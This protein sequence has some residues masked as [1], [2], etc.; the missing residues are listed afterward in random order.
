MDRCRGTNSLFVGGF[1]NSCRLTDANLKNLR[2]INQD[3]YTLNSIFFFR[4]KILTQE[5][6]RSEL[7]DR[8]LIGTWTALQYHP[9]WNIYSPPHASAFFMKS[10]KIYNPWGL[11]FLKSGNIRSIWR[12]ITRSRWDLFNRIL[13]DGTEKKGVN[14]WMG[15]LWALIARINT[16]FNGMGS[17]VRGM[18]DNIIS[19]LFLVLWK[20]WLVYSIR[21]FEMTIFL[22]ILCK[23]R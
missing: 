18:S 14:S 6:R 4:L 20:R 1:K 8:D 16:R 11:M 12:L 15:L 7:T 17:R 13:G 2:T 23:Y 3:F 21:T 19:Q 22:Q 10:L 5:M 9:T